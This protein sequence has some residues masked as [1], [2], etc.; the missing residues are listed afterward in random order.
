MLWSGRLNYEPLRLL[1]I[2]TSIIQ[3]K[4]SMGQR[5]ILG[6]T[7]VTRRAEIRGGVCGHRAGI[8]DHKFFVWNVNA[9]WIGNSLHTI[10]LSSLK[11]LT[12]WSASSYN[13]QEIFCEFLLADEAVNENDITWHEQ[14]RTWRRSRTNSSVWKDLLYYP[15]LLRESWS[16]LVSR[17]DIYGNWGAFFGDQ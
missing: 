1:V 12:Y 10:L 11:F 9:Y 2:D 16:L 7:W 14:L 17:D 3:Q 13:R 4:E 15:S 8:S 5:T 6:E